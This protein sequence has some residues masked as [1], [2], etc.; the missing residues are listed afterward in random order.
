[1]KTTVRAGRHLERMKLSGMRG[2]FKRGAWYR[3]AA[4][5]IQKCADCQRKL[6]AEIVRG[7][8]LVAAW[9]GAF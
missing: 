2:L 8:R 1:M 5:H 7:E 6:E 9:E 3:T 4:R